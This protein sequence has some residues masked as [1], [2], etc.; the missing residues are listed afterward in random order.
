ML[1]AFSVTCVFFN[2]FYAIMGYI[3]CVATVK[4]VLYRSKPKDDFI[5][6]KKS[7]QHFSFVADF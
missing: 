3:K 5:M 4:Q 2:R 1:V 7:P 6:N